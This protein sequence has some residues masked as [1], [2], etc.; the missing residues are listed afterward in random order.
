MRIILQKMLYDICIIYVII[1]VICK[2]F[3]HKKGGCLMKRKKLLFLCVMFCLS[4][5]M[6]ISV[7]AASKQA[8]IYKEFLLNHP[9]YTWFRTLDINKDGV[10]ELIISE[11]QQPY[12]SNIYYIY[13]VKKEKMVYLGRVS[14]SNTFK[15]GTSKV[16]FYNSKLK[17]IREVVTGPHSL[18]LSLYKISGSTLKGIA[19]SNETYGRF[20]V[21]AFT[22]NG[23]DTYYSTTTGIKKFKQLVDQY[24]YK[25]CKKYTL[26][27]NNAAN[28]SSKL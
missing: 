21:Y 1:K 16:I 18:G 6:S 10:K 2:I 7:Q 17:A 27:K 3:L 12:R 25:G 20:P 9:S 5:M 13:T 22:K 19:Y 28:R 24:F 23:K 8:P 11:N 4:L 26:Y 15:D 14:H